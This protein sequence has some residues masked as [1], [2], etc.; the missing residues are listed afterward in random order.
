MNKENES[1]NTLLKLFVGAAC[2]AC[3]FAPGLAAA[4]NFKAPIHIVVPYAAGGGSDALARFVAPG[5]SKELGQTIIIEN[6]VGAGGQIG[7]QL[8]QA[9]PADGTVLMV[10]PDPALTSLP[11]TSPNVKY[12]PIN[13]FRPLGQIA[14]TAWAFSIPA[15][16]PY[17]DFKEYSAALRREP[18]LRAYG[19]PLAG[20]AMDL[21]GQAIGKYIGSEMVTIPF[22]GSAPVIQ[23]VMAG[24]VPAGITGMPEAM[25]VS[26]SGKARVIAVSGVERTPLM[27]DTPTF[28]ELGLPGLE[29]YT[30]VGVFA[31]KGFPAAM[32]QEFNIA[33]RK[34]LADPAVLEKIQALGLSPAPTT[35]DEATRELETLTRFWKQALLSKN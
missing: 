27:P 23:N 30:F 15:T 3:L 12:D 19:V 20:G 29:F 17:K 22:S 10:T 28:K 5:L 13:D 7:A 33:L 2:T 11:F 4:Q 26:R 31:P 8:V 1:M 21:I 24:Q 14:R 32:A 16:A 35:I 18:T 6:K 34:T 25:A 9:A